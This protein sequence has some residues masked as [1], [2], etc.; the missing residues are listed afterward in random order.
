MGFEVA[1]V[2]QCSASL[3]FIIRLWQCNSLKVFASL[4]CPCADA[5][6]HASARPSEAAPAKAR[7]GSHRL[8]CLVCKE[9]VSCD[10]RHGLPM[11]GIV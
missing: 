11:T 8:L 7:Y 5:E 3:Q 1:H 6:S 9:E 4:Y 2:E 10:S